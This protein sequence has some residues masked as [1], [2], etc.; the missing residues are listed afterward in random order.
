[1]YP[2]GSF[3]QSARGDTSI[4]T[5]GGQFYCNTQQRQPPFAPAALAPYAH[6]PRGCRHDPWIQ[7]RRRIVRK[8]HSCVLLLGVTWGGVA[9]L[10]KEP[11]PSKFLV[12]A[13]QQD[14]LLIAGVVGPILDYP[15]ITEAD[16]GTLSHTQRFDLEWA[17]AKPIR[18]DGDEKTF[19]LL[20]FA[21]QPGMLSAPEA[22][23]YQLMT[24]GGDMKAD[25]KQ[26]AS[27]TPKKGDPIGFKKTDKGATAAAGEKTFDFAAASVTTVYWRWSL[28][29]P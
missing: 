20:G 19:F 17:V 27:V 11:S 23:T 12:T 2:S 26:L 5:T 10:A 16:T 18:E 6:R 14:Q 15:W 25:P 4:A 3:T 24:T 9:A 21:S 22:G 28:P 29:K 1:M 7:S 8:V 13:L